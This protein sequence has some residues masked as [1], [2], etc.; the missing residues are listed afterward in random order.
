MI[1]GKVINVE[2]K[3]SKKGKAYQKLLVQ[4]D[5]AFGYCFNFGDKMYSVG[6]AVD[7]TVG[8]DYQN[9]LRLEVK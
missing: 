3:K 5:N 8:V 4:V 9:Y 2:L 7:F 1:K 6:D